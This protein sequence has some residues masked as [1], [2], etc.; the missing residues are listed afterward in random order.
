MMTDAGKKGTSIQN[1]MWIPKRAV[2]SRKFDRT[3]VKTFHENFLK[4]TL[5]EI[6]TKKLTQSIV[7][8][9]ERSRLWR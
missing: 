2:S 3:L 5:H 9:G 6:W 7:V 4:R 1:F 8:F